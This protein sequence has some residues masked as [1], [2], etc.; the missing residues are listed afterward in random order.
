MLQH[1]SDTPKFLDTKEMA[2]HEQCNTCDAV[3][4]DL[5]SQGIETE[6]HRAHTFSPEDES[7]HWENGVLV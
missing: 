2:F 3:Y 7:K 1:N 5:H 4:C 6:V